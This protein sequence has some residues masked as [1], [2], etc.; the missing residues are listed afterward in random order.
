MNRSETRPLVILLMGPP[1]SGKGTHAGPLSQHLSIPHISTGDLFRENIRNQTS[2]GKK[3]KSFID[4]GNLVPDELVL[5][6]LFDRVSKED[7]KNGYVLDG[8]PRTIPQAK[9]LDLR[10]K[11]THKIIALNFHLDDS[12]IV[13]RITGRIA[14]KDCGRPHHK[15][16]DP[17][18]K[19]MTCDSCG[20]PLYQRDDDKEAIILKRLQVYREQTEP[21]IAHYAAQKGV[22]KQIDSKNSKAQVFSD[23]LD[24]LP[25]TLVPISR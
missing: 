12:I 24:A 16:Y 14:C 20:G 18:R 1:G 6:M 9:A 5:D 4:L 19:E 10:L 22:L 15:K 17:P 3:A 13:E 25:D 8:S 7:C 11:G 2:L 23:V 21:L